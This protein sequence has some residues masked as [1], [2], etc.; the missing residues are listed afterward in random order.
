MGEACVEGHGICDACLEGRASRVILGV[1]ALTEEKDPVAIAS[2]LT[3]HPRLRLTLP[4]HE[5]VVEGALLAAFSNVRSEGKERATRVAELATKAPGNPGPSG[6]G[7]AEAAGAFVTF[8]AEL[9]GGAEGL[10][11]RASE[12]ARELIG[13]GEDALCPR[14]NALVSILFAARF[15]REHLSLELPARGLACERAGKNPTCVGA[16]C[17]FNR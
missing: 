11:R 2:R 7:S 17:P 1:C 14:R 15:A 13:E 16:A 3:L 8:A 5:L 4:E 9:L 12:R 10:S 6:R